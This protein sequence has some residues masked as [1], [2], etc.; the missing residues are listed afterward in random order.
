[1]RFGVRARQLELELSDPA[2]TSGAV[3][4][5]GGG[6][7]VVLN[8]A[9]PDG[10]LLCRFD[11]STEMEEASRL[12]RT[13]DRLVSEG[14][15]GEALTLYTK[16]A[17][18]LPHADDV[19]NE[20]LTQRNTLQVQFRRDQ[21]RLDQLVEGA[22][23]FKTEGNYQQ[24]LQEGDRLMALYAGAASETAELQKRRSRVQTALDQLLGERAKAAAL[25]LGAVEASLRGS[26][27]V[28]LADFIKSY[29]NTHHAQSAGGTPG[30]N[31]NEGKD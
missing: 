27:S 5:G 10:K 2:P 23:F 1:V 15:L 30:S 20:V 29:I 25:S 26:G 14:K 3:S 4:G 11:F 31:G 6:D 22:E 17:Q 13:A 9:I 28:V 18:E 8:L 19:L 21:E 24:S 16:V 7:Q 12:K